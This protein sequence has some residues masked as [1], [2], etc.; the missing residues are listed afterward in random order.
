MS[1]FFAERDILGAEVR[2]GVAIL[3]LRRPE[4]MNAMSPDL[5]RALDE[6]LSQVPR[7][8]SVRAILLTGTGTRS[9]R[10]SPPC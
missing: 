9:A 3:T 2:D 7:D 4:S 10:C 5:A 6:T 1:T 8:G